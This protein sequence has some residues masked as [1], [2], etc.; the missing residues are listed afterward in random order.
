MGIV[1]NAED[2]FGKGNL[3]LA[4]TGPIGLDDSEAESDEYQPKTGFAEWI[5]NVLPSVAE[6]WD[7]LGIKGRRKAA[8]IAVGGIAALGAIGYATAPQE[9]TEFYQPSAIYT[10]KEGDTASE[11]ALEQLRQGEQSRGGS[12][13]DGSVSDQKNLQEY[14]NELED[15]SGN[16]ESSPN[17]IKPEHV[18]KLPTVEAKKRTSRIGE[19]LMNILNIDISDKWVEITPA[20]A[21]EQG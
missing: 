17:E 7:K 2:R 11:I 14:I 5:N 13:P 19:F 15:E 18:F 21:S 3:E 1:I 20:S 6:Y 4:P 9:S 16:L 10:V 12:L 8:A